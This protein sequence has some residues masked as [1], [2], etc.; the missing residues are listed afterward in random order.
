MDNF[1]DFCPLANLDNLNETLEQYGVAV[2]P[3][4]FAEDECDSYRQKIFDYI[5]QKHQIK[6]PDDY[7]V[8]LK[9][10]R[11]GILHF[12][13]LGLIEPVLD[14]KT[15]ER[16]VEAFRRIW[17]QADEENEIELTTSLDGIN[18]APPPEKTK[19]KTFFKPSDVTWFHF[20]QP[21]SDD[22]EPTRVK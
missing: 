4:V 12:Y 2:L 15:D 7:E 20:D 14:I 6:R 19:E 1:A 13:G 21:T 22:D 9:S 10:L 5:E 8:K 3:D 16:V 17:R 18:I 11:G